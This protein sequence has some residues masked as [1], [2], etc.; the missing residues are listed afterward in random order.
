MDEAKKKHGGAGRGQ[1]RKV[2]GKAKMVVAPIRLEPEQKA[3]LQRI[4][5]AAWVR[6]KIDDEPEP[7]E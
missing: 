7:K 6:R 1:G 5:G 4:G 2:Q 3:K